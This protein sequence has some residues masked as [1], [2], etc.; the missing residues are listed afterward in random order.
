MPLQSAG[1][2]LYQLRDDHLQ[3]FLAHP[4]GPFWAK[5]DDGVWS[6]PK[7]LYDE[8]EE[9]L[10]AARREFHE[11]IGTRLDAPDDAF[12]SLGQLKQKGNKIVHAWAIEGDVDAETI[13]SNTYAVQWPKGTWRRYPEVDRAGWFSVD[14]ARIK[15]LPGQAAFIDR[16]LAVLDGSNSVDD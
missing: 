8:T 5:K 7:G 1:L 16:L 2:L 11:E 4:G 10:A 9:P 12:V 15:I 14:E 3:L 6:I 13:K